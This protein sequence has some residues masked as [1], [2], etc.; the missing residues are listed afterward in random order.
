MLKDAFEIVTDIYLENLIGISDVTAFPQNIILLFQRFKKAYESK[1]IEG[2][3]DTISDSFCG[4]FYGKSK[5]RFLATM[6]G[7]FNRLPFGVSPHLIIS[8]KN[9]S[10][11]TEDEFSAIIEMNAVVKAL[12]IP[13]PTK[14][15]SG[16]VLCEAKPEGQLHYWRITKLLR[17]F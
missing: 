9:I 15:D 4:D 5:T 7:T 12:F 8:I 2:L 14:F 13:L 3:G 1:N 17:T 6:K 10:S 16:E 11:H